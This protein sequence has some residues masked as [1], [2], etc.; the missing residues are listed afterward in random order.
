[1]AWY[2]RIETISLLANAIHHNL[3][4]EHPFFLKSEQ[5]RMDQK[6]VWQEELE[7]DYGVVEV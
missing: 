2:L 7:W 1:V 4:T 3:G 5:A 6:V